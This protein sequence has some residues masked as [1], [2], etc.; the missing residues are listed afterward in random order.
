[1]TEFKNH[2]TNEKPETLTKIEKFYENEIYKIKNVEKIETT[3][4]KR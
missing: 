1:M 2:W 3:F 4:G